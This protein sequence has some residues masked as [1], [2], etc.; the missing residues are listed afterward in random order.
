M[1]IVTVVGARPQF[2][3]AAPMSEA[4]R[5]SGIIEYLLHTGQHYDAQMSQVFFNDLNLPTPAANLGIGSGSHAQQTAA[6]LV[7]IEQV[8]LAEQPDWVIVFGDTNSTLAGALAAIKLHI[9]VVHIEAGLRSYN[10][11][12]PE[13]HNRVLTDHCSDLLFCPTQTAVANLHQEGL[14]RGIYNVGDVMYD[15]ILQNLA[16]AAE[17]TNVV[18]SLGLASQGYYLA[19]L[20]RP[21]NVDDPTR[22]HQIM[23]ALNELD[24]PVILPLHPRTQARLLS[25]DESISHSHGQSIQILNSKFQNLTF[26][27]PQGYLDMLLL[28]Q[29]AKA[30]L[31]DSG[32]VQKEAYCLAVPCLTLRNE[33]EWV[34]TLRDGW[35]QL[36]LVDQPDLAG[37]L[38]RAIHT[39]PGT[40]LPEPVFGDG[41]AAQQIAQ[42]LLTYSRT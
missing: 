37:E 2:I 7:G 26:I 30:I 27:P 17:R 20:H 1:K 40:S 42:I 19:T 8:L 38:Q 34:E 25:P 14:N 35:N 31:T 6:M 10:R 41:T 39:P 9:P 11:Q 32:G 28:E 3:K 4:L 29:S 36:V 22:L 21:V 33:T 5:A 15:A 16:R 18:G 23:L 12:M 24:R 13:E